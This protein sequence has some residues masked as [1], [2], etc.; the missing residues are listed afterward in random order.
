MITLN[1]RKICEFTVQKLGGKGKKSS[2]SLK[3]EK[4]PSHTALLIKR[5]CRV[6]HVE[7][8]I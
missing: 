4:I 8:I 5:K 2:S 1:K 7:E 3:K 6:I